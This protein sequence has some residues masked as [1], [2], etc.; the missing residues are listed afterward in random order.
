VSPVLVDANV[1]HDVV[2]DDPPRCVL[3]FTLEE[4]RP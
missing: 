1:L 2:S 3:L 4:I